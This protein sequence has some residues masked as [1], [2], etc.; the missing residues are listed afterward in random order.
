MAVSCDAQDLIAQANCIACTVPQ[1]AQLSVLISLLAKAAGVSS[2]PNSLVEAAKCIA[3]TIPEGVRWSVLVYLF[4][5][6]AGTNAVSAD[7][8]APLMAGCDTIGGVSFQLEWNNRAFPQT[9]VEV[10]LNINGAG[11][12]LVATVGPTETTYTSPGPYAFPDVVCGKVRAVN[13]ALVSKF[14]GECCRGF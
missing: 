4:C 13:G 2:N 9:G 3:C 7:P 10:W 12:S 8:K 11:Y 1:G 5:Q 6:L 14:S